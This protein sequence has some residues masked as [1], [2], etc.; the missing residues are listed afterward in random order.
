MDVPLGP[1]D[2]P[3]WGAGALGVAVGLIIW[4]CFAFATS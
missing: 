3:A 2:W 1:I 4:F